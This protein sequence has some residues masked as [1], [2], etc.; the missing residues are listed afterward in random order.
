MAAEP[1]STA[2]RALEPGAAGT[3]DI[4]AGV[5]GQPHHVDEMPVPGGEFEAQMLLR[6]KL[7]E[8]GAEQADDQEYCADDDVSAVE[9]RRHEKGCAVDRIR[10]RERRMI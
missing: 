10:K 4:D 5:Q 6:R 2:R 7:A 1:P 3:P 9:A 8:L